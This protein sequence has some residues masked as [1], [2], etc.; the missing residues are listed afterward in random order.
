[1]KTSH[2]VFWICHCGHH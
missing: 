2:S 1:M